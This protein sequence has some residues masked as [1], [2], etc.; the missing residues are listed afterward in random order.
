MAYCMGICRAE[1]CVKPNRIIQENPNSNAEQ[2]LDI[3]LHG[4]EPE[5]FVNN[6]L[7]NS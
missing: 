5:Y 7:E 2:S 1:K 3:V 6:Y 4:P